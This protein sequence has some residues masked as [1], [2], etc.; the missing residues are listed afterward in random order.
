LRQL[1]LGHNP[2]NIGTGYFNR[3]TSAP[4][5]PPPLHRHPRKFFPV[6]GMAVF[7][8]TFLDQVFLQLLDHI[9]QKRAFSI[10][11]SNPDLEFF[12]LSCLR[13]LTYLYQKMT[14]IA[15]SRWVHSVG[16]I[17]GSRQKAVVGEHQKE[18]CVRPQM[19]SS[20]PGPVCATYLRP[21]KRGL[22][23][24]GSRFGEG[25]GEDSHC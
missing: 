13:K 6:D 24:G 11:I 23:V 1:P 15:I 21:P 4:G 25:R 17:E 22:R 12:Y 5:Y 10:I 16:K 7:F 20:P 3:A 9:L 8:R 14:I 2:R 19:I 18:I